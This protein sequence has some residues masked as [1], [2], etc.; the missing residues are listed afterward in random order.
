[1]A[2]TS[3]WK[4]VLSSGMCLYLCCSALG[5]FNLDHCTQKFL[6]IN[7]AKVTPVSTQNN[8]AI[9]HLMALNPKVPCILSAGRM[10]IR[11]KILAGPY[12][13]FRKQ[14]SLLT[15]KFLVENSCP[16]ILKVNQKWGICVMWL[17]DAFI[18]LSHTVIY[19]TLAQV[20][21]N[22]LAVCH[23]RN[24]VNSWQ[25]WP[26]MTEWELST[27]MRG[28]T[29]LHPHLNGALSNGKLLI[30]QWFNRWNY[31]SAK[32]P[33]LFEISEI[34]PP[35]S[36]PFIFFFL[37]PAL[38]CLDSCKYSSLGGCFSRQDFLNLNSI[39]HGNTRQ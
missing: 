18:G 36:L 31:M 27:S 13:F 20:M 32:L 14:L 24:D 22:K 34:F 33:F 10:F 9:K 16:R 25:M 8:F 37:F 38:I 1:M 28:L 3:G 4:P 12:L 35:C 15:T 39:M 5:K 7:T 17:W 19:T 23:R 30:I 11:C 6:P 2:D 29:F 21:W 26:P